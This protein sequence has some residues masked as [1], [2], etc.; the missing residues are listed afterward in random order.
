QT[1]DVTITFRYLTQA[2]LTVTPRAPQ[3]LGDVITFTPASGTVAAGA[4]MQIT[5]RFTPTT[6][7][8]I[9][10]SLEVVADGRT[11][12]LAMTGAGIAAA[13]VT[14]VGVVTD[15]NTR[16]AL[17]SVR[18]AALDGRRASVA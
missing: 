16:L 17:G 18:V 5:F 4:T 11:H 1:K 6:P 2:A 7:G 3:G 15:A 13:P 8:S 9:A 12:S 10:G 14:V